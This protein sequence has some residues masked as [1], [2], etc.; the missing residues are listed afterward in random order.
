MVPA[1]CP[2]GTLPPSTSRRWRAAI[3]SDHGTTR[4]VAHPVA[5]S[6]KSEAA[7]AGVDWILL[8]FLG[9]GCLR[10]GHVTC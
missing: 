7:G 4:D 5:G 3:P 9:F 2:W 1:A 8:K 10:L 6:Q